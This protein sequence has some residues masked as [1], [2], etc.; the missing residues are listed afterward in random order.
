MSIQV[1]PPGVDL[2]SLVSLEGPCE[3]Q[4]LKALRRILEEAGTLDPLAVMAP[5][6]A[7]L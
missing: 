7:A 4:L 1:L 6:N 5:F 2:T 3:T